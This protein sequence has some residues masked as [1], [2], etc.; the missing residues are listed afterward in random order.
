MKFLKRKKTFLRCIAGVLIFVSCGKNDI[1]TPEPKPGPGLEQTFDFKLKS[2]NIVEFKKIVNSKATELEDE[3]TASIFGG[4]I[5]LITPDELQFTENSLIIVKPHGM[6]E[7]YTIQWVKD[8]LFLYNDME[9]V[10]DYCGE[11]KGKDC[12]F[13]NT[14][15]FTRLSKNEQRVLYVTAQDYSLT[16]F[17]QILVDPDD[18]VVWLRLE[19]VY[20]K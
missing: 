11:L 16:S 10:W 6:V 19:F 17:D 9:D 12:F 13:L 3:D 20:E 14:A 5:D 4:R 8:E 7:E 15:L 18:E 2:S 1:P